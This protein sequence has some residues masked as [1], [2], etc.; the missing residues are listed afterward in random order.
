MRGG[1]YQLKRLM[2]M[3]I[4][5]YQT[6]PTI[7]I[8]VKN[9]RLYNTKIIH[10]IKIF[11]KIKKTKPISAALFETITTHKK[12]TTITNYHK[13]KSHICLTQ[14]KE[15]GICL[16]YNKMTTFY[17]NLNNLHQC[18]YYCLCIIIILFCTHIWYKY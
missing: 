16:Y 4:S 17:T 6:N 8:T 13:I 7:C 5:W 1:R 18:Y 10:I 12:K 2:Q 11:S 15:Q 14:I 9:L 3:C